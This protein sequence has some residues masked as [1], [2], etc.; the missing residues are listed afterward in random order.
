MSG[1]VDSVSLVD[2]DALAVRWHPADDRL[3]VDAPPPSPDFDHDRIGVR[4]YRIG[5]DAERRP[6]ELFPPTESVPTPLAPLLTDARAGAIV[7]L[8]DG[9]YVGPAS[10]PPGVILRGLGAGRTTIEAPIPNGP[11]IVPTPATIELGRSAR[12]EHL[13]VAGRADRSDWRQPSV[14]L[15]REPFAT[16]LGCEVAGH[17]EIA[18]DDALLRAV[19][20]RSLTATHANRLAI[21]RST[22]VGNRWNV[23]VDLR[24]GDAQEIESCE[25]VDHLWSIRAS[26][27][28]GTRL[29]GNRISGRWW[30][31]HLEQADGAHVHGNSI[32]HTMRAVDVDG[33]TGSIVEGNAVCDGDSGCLVHAG[34]SDTVVRGNRWER[35]RAGMIEWSATGL[36][37][38][39]NVCVDLHDPDAAH[40]TGP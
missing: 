22:F 10:V 3:V 32:D 34:A 29:R 33:G 14:V 26:G 2:D 37:H 35:C 12:L 28:S 31:I 7:Q 17:I 21:S 1:H 15:L 20:A 39:D 8:G 5:F 18:A 36:V 16:M 27:T 13:T 4:A 9:R 25:F 40:V 38:V 23:G 11:S 30:A 19:T 24:G 6:V